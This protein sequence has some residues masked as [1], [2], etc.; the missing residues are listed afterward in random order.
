MR[1]FAIWGR[2]IGFLGGA[3]V[4]YHFLRRSPASLDS[5]LRAL[6]AGSLVCAVIGLIGIHGVSAVYGLFRG[7]LSGAVDPAAALKSYGSAVA[8]LIPVVVWAGWRLGCAWRVAGLA[9]V[10]LAVALI[11]AADSKA[12]LFGLAVAAA[13][14]AMVML[15][16]RIS[17][18][19]A[20][21]LAL[22]AATAVF[23]VALGIVMSLLPA[24]PDA[25]LLASGVYDGPLEIPLPI[26]LLDA[27]RQ[28]IWGFALH[29]A[30]ESPWIGHGIDVSNLLPGAHSIITRFNQEFIPS[31]PHSWLLE[32]FAE[33]GA[34]GL[35]ILVVA[36]GLTVRWWLRAGGM[37]GASGIALFGAFWGSSLLNF[38]LWAAWWQIT[39]AVLGAIVLAGTARRD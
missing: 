10:P 21:A 29:A 23:G 4:I 5:A 37:A 24:P 33:T 20:A 11:F 34:I 9:Y 17:T 25:A 18:G 8:C 32:V 12:G 15:L 38:S 2:M 16:R 6:I 22:L 1:S 14:A 30:L 39:F 19:R 26:W 27:H 3:A 36:L 7:D 35:A 28:Q 31:H 13:L